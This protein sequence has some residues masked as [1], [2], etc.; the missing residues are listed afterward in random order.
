[1]LDIIIAG[2]G[3]AGLTSAIYAARAGLK[4][5]VI[6]RAF[7]GGQAGKTHFIEN[8]PGFENGIT[9]FDF[10]MS[11]TNQ[12][13]KFGV[14]IT[15]EEI[16]SFDLLGKEKIV[17]TAENEYKAKAIILAMG[18]SPR[19]LGLPGEKELTGKGVSYCA[20]CDG[21]F[22]KGQKVA[23][24]GG[25]DTAGEDAMYLSTI[26]DTVYLVHRRDEYRMQYHLSKKISEKQ[27][28]VPVL[29]SIPLS[30]EGED[31]LKGLVVENVKDKKTTTLELSG[32]FVAVG[33]A[34]ISDK[35]KDQVELE[36]GYIIADQNMST[37]VP[38]V[39]AAG[40]I[41][42]KPLRQIVTA[43]SDGAIAVYSATNYIMEN[44]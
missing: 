25:G 44:F 19:T 38:G 24:I 39:F 10:A 7:P 28:I 31:K 16:E 22:F 8:Y 15:Y 5:V 34:P 1:M 23:V 14:N 26:C 43:V 11:L 3:P 30:F 32:A 29:S 41:V 2:A 42:K 18:A 13:Q 21:A 27:N 9:G 4:V 33:V 17:K 35:I 36:K 40:D 6:E 37:N 20:T 12:A